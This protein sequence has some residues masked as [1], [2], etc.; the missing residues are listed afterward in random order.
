M[1]WKC[2][3]HE[4][5]WS[6]AVSER[7]GRDKTGCQVCAETGFN[8]EDAAWLYLAHHPKWLLLQI[9]I[10]NYPDRRLKTHENHGWE[11]LDIRGPMDGYLTQDWEASILRWLTSRNIPRAASGT[12]ESPHFDTPNSGEAWQQ[13]DLTVTSVRE[14]MDLGEADE[15]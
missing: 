6:A 7:T 4:H 8:P 10:T 11:V 15:Q 13:S 2:A 14:I 12:E 1:P 9:G 5:E 3:A